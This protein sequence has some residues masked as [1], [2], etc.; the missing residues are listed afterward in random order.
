MA[1]MMGIGQ[2]FGVTP[3]HMANAVATLVRNGE[4]LSPRICLD[5][6]T[7]QV[8]RKLPVTS[9]ALQVVRDGMAQVVNESGGTGYKV[10]HEGEPLKVAVCGKT[11]TAQAAPQRIDSNGDGR[12]DR[13]D[14]IVRQ[15][16]MAWF[17]GYA[18][19]ENPEIAFAVV[20]EYVPEHGNI[21]AG[22]LAR[23]L[24]RAAQNRYLSP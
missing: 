4:F 24:V 2:S 12:I 14:P 9:E 21:I 20:V 22:P 19:R 10:F 16:N 17:I 6:A 8:R 23:E 11:G 18:P 7:P 3:L 15:G 1:R 13:S 5:E